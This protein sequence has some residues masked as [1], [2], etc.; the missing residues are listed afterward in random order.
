[1]RPLAPILLAAVSLACAG[2]P[3]VAPDPTAGYEKSCPEAVRVYPT[4]DRVGKE[5]HE[6]AR[7][8]GLSESDTAG[9][10]GALRARREKAAALGANGIILDAALA[11]Y[12][13]ED[14]GSAREICAGGDVNLARAAERAAP[15]ALGYVLQGS[16]TADIARDSAAQDAARADVNRRLNAHR[17]M[18]EA[19]ADVI[20]LR[21]VSEYTEVRP[22][23]L[24]LTTGEG[25]PNATSLEYNLRRLHQAYRGV[26]YYQMPA[27][28]ELWRDGRKIGEYTSDGLLL[29]GDSSARP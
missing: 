6:I 29:G 3:A 15:D 16:A 22:G 26:L 18:R 28:L 25:Y 14:A 1:M 2:P 21:I 24:V 9:E 19:L 20:R 23:L 5:Y 13:P 27:V 7:L 10:E 12:V 8:T 17:A 4:K 11:I